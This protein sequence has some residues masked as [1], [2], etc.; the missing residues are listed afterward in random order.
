MSSV[1]RSIL[2]DDLDLPADEV[3][4]KARIRGVTAPEKSIRDTV[5][6]IRSELKKK[7]AKSS[8]SK[9][10]VAPT[11]R[12]PEPAPVAIPEVVVAP[13]PSPSPS[14]SV[15]DL[16]SVLANV[17]RVNTVIGECGGAETARQ[18]VEAIRACGSVDAFLQNLDLIATI[19]GGT[20]A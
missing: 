17:A 9:P 16:S 5:Y 6:G 14:P 4:R 18:V 11:T 12:T 2:S 7:S 10:V 15:P 20:S 13:V 19:R 8:P 3:I 1:V